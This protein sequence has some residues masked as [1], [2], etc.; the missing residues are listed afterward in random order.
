[1]CQKVWHD[2]KKKN[3]IFYNLLLGI[4]KND[5]K[6]LDIVGVPTNAKIL[7]ETLL[8][9]LLNFLACLPNPTVS[10]FMFIKNQVSQKHH[11]I[12]KNILK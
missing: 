6:S 1:M 9:L 4:F 11:I 5:L 12:E 8:K 3:Y 2:L 10:T 7:H